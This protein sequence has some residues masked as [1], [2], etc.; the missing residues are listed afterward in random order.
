RAPD[1]PVGPRAARWVLP[2]PSVARRRG[3]VGALLFVLVRLAVLLLAPLVLAVL[4]LVHRLVLPVLLSVL[5]P[6]LLSELGLS[7]GSRRSGGVIGLAG[8]QDGR[9]LLGDLLA[10]LRDLVQLL[11]VGLDGLRVGL[12]RSVQPP[13]L[14]PPVILLGHVQVLAG[15]LLQEAP[16]R[17]RRLGGAPHALNGHGFALFE[18]FP[19]RENVDGVGALLAG[20][21][22]ALP[23]KIG[24][25]VARPRLPKTV[26][27]GLLAWGHGLVQKAVQLL[28]GLLAPLGVVL[29]RLAQRSVLHA[30]GQPLHFGR[31]Q[32]V[33][34]HHLPQ[35]GGLVLG[36]VGQSDSSLAGVVWP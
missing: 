33:V 15:Q 20:R 16:G 22:A 24:V 4:A 18:A 13:L 25:L 11:V 23:A 28:G 27:L 6:V 17:L 10:G 21:I 7:I 3:S 31:Q 14:Q 29:E 26:G 2:A 35:L 12:G 30:L 19:G 36:H 8:R 1:V 5:L 9:G 32:M 34:A